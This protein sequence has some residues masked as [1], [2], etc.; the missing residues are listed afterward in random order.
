M[1]DL[2]DVLVDGAVRGEVA[3][4]GNVDDRAAPPGAGVVEL[5][6]HLLLAGVV[7]KVA[8][9]QVGVRHA[10]VVAEEQRVVELG[11]DAVRAERAVDEL[12]HDAEAAAQTRTALEDYGLP[13]AAYFL[14]T[15]LPSF[16]LTLDEL[17]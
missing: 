17:K 1:P 7:G 14:E 5:S 2:V 4:L 8:Q 16:S 6:D 15:F 12:V 10:A 11:E 13:E 3:G 9:D